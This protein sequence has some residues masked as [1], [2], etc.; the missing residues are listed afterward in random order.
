MSVENL[1]DQWGMY[2]GLEGI[3]RFYF[4]L[5]VVNYSNLLLKLKSDNV[6]LLSL[7]LLLAFGKTL[8]C[9]YSLCAVPPSSEHVF[10]SPRAVSSFT[11]PALI[12]STVT[13]PSLI[14]VPG[15]GVTGIRENY[16]CL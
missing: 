5:I 16:V 11:S 12:T 4:M 15:I 9:G 14:S 6:L 7:K 1:V 2:I 13:T 8:F 10:I 3:K